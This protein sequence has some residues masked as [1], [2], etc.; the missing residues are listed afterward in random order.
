[1][2]LKCKNKISGEIEEFKEYEL[3]NYEIR[4]KRRTKFIRFYILNNKQYPIYKEI[5]KKKE[6]L[7]KYEIIN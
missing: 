5:L 1:M 6:F 4:T 3:S 7:E 2:I